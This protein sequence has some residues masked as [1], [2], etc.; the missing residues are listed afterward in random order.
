VVVA[1]KTGMRTNEVLGLRWTDIDWDHARVHVR[2][3][4]GGGDPKTDA[5]ER[6]IA[7]HAEALAALRRLR[8]YAVGL[9]GIGGDG[10]QLA[11]VIEEAAE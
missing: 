7:L 6:A 2:R 8:P 10:K 11:K 9:R 1:T 5:G 4:R 3:Q